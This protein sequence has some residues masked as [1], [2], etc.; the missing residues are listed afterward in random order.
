[1]RERERESLLAAANTV[2]K[3]HAII[4]ITKPPLLFS[5]SPSLSLKNPPH[6]ATSANDD[7]STM[8]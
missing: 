1:M 4:S 8:R 5:L 3:R 6:R 7:T 2:H